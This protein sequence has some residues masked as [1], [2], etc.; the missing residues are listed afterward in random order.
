MENRI[1]EFQGDLFADRLSC[2]KY[3]SNQFRMLLSAVAYTLMLKMKNLI[4]DSV[5]PYC[6][7]IRLKLIKVATIIRTNSRKVYIQVSKNF[8][9][10]DLFKKHQKAPFSAK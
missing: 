6:S 4:N 7:T 2:H 1:K 3:K 5:I 9:H 8:P 10:L